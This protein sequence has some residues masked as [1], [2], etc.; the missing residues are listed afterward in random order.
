MKLCSL[1]SRLQELNAYL[2]VFP[3]DTEGQE[4]ASLP[5]DEILDIIYHSM[6]NTWKNKM[7]EQG[8]NYT[9]STIKEMTDFFETRV[10]N[11]EPKE[12][13]KKSSAAV[14]KSKKTNKKRKRD[15]SDSSV[16]ESSEESIQDH[17]P[18]KKYCILHD[19]CS[20]STDNCKDLRAMVSK[21]K[22]RNKKSFNNYGKSNKELNALIEKKFQKFVKNKKRRKTEKELQHFQEM[23][24]SDNESK[25]SVSSFD[26]SVEDGEISTSN[27]E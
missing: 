8:F 18:I 16:V 10:E 4:T 25:K 21:H 2:K 7:I 23:Q 15:V 11:L 24:I 17:C 27:S 13:K 3:P 26:E 5:S 22:K 20:H 9:D 12:E 19:K 6:P 1:I 14:K